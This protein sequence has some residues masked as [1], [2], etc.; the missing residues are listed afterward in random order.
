MKKFLVIQTAFIGDAILATGVLEKLHAFYPEAHIDFIV[1]RGNEAL[2][3]GHPFINRLYVWDK[4]GGKYRNLLR[5]LGEIRKQRYDYTINLQRFAATGFLTV[6]SKAKES[7]GFNKNPWSRF[8]TKSIV[9]EV[10]AGA[11]TIHEVDRNNKL[12]AHITYG[13]AAKPR[14]YTTPAVQEKVRPYTSG[15]Y[16][17]IAP[18]SVWFTKQFPA[19]KWVD[20]IN[21]IKP[22]YTIYLLGAKADGPLAEQ[23]TQYAR[24]D[25]LI[26]LTGKLT[27]LESAAVMEK[28]AMNYVND[29]APLHLASSLNAPVTAVYCSTVPYFGFGPL[30]TQSFIVQT[31][32][33][34]H[35]KP[36]GLHGRASCP[37]GHF[38]CALTISNQQLLAVLQ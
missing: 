4:K 23:I 20:L 35:C 36:C 28:A 15:K 34:L 17:C 19:Q 3:A 38:D 8:F 30:S 21:S 22:S 5:L 16:I 2:F 11:N 13:K 14:L 33:P 26:D 7:I 18:A 37:K 10:S 1:R 24:H 25:G 32:K 29:S 31:N 6:F 27:L 12:I 9:H